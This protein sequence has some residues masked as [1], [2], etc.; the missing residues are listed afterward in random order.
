MAMK[1]K[2]H[3]LPVVLAVSLVVPGNL[4]AG[5]GPAAGQRVDAWGD[6]LPDGALFRLGSTRFHHLHEISDMRFSPDGR[7]LTAVAGNGMTMTWDVATGKEKRRTKLRTTYADSFRRCAF[8]SEGDRVLAVG[9]KGFLLASG[10][11][12]AKQLQREGD[13]VAGSFFPDGTNLF[14]VDT[15]T[16]LLQVDRATGRVIRY[17]RLRQTRSQWFEFGYVFSR[18]SRWLASSQPQGGLHVWDTKTAKRVYLLT[19]KDKGCF[20][21]AFSPDARFIAAGF[22]RWPRPDPSKLRDRPVV[23]WDLKNGKE[24]RRFHVNYSESPSTARASERHHQVFRFSPDGKLLAYVEGPIDGEIIWVWDVSTGKVRYRLEA[25]H[26]PPGCLEFSPDGKMLA[27]GGY[28]GAVLIWNL[29]TGKVL[30]YPT[31][32]PEVFAGQPRYVAGGKRFLLEHWPATAEPDRR[33]AIATWDLARGKKVQNI[34]GK[35]LADVSTPGALLGVYDAYVGD[36][37]ETLNG[38]LNTSVLDLASGAPQ[39]HS[40]KL[41]P[42]IRFSDDGKRLG[43]LGTVMEVTDAR[44]GKQLSR[45]R[46]SLAKDGPKTTY[47]PSAD[48]RYMARAGAST[49]GLI[50]LVTGRELWKSAAISSDSDGDRDLIVVFSPDAEFLAAS[51]KGILLGGP[52]DFVVWQTK[53]GKKLFQRQLAGDLLGFMPDSRSVLFQRNDEQSKVYTWK[54]PQNRPGQEYRGRIRQD[55]ANVGDNS[56]T[57]RLFKGIEAAVSP[58]SKVLVTAAHHVAEVWET[59][60]GTLLHRIRDDR[61]GVGQPTLAPDC[62]TITTVNDNGTITVWDLTGLRLAEQKR[63]IPLSAPDFERCWTSLADTEDGENFFRAFWKLAADPEQTV[64]RLRDRI[65]A[66]PVTDPKQINRWMEELDSKESA[67]RS[68]AAK[69]LE[70]DES[71]LPILRVASKNRLSLEAALRVTRIV[72]M[73]EMGP[74]RSPEALRTYR[75]VQLLEQI[76]TPA[77]VDLLRTLGRGASEAM[78]TR[79]AQAS[80][81]RLR[82]S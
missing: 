68:R 8:T 13:F 41:M 53:T 59:A 45:S 17:A 42:W 48:L 16:N 44:T 21:A 64:A 37:S 35:H 80:L 29:T 27:A 54:L 49:V 67:R 2:R 50:D 79:E 62:R 34:P 1:F 52:G 10:K 66:V 9:Y 32:L 25:F 12:G 5:G 39:W 20:G 28:S 40:S 73:L 82:G 30:G 57:L 63:P 70:V 47:T 18:D 58:D 43:N 3:S 26:R 23:L 77:A 51:R 46:L 14:L 7:T 76:G 81:R 19:E 33:L 36:R 55:V 6:P 61:D 71:V 31:G 74:A 4:H 24:V 75:A 22:D 11:D 38:P 72:D 56:C 65:K 60:T 15:A 78:L 69:A